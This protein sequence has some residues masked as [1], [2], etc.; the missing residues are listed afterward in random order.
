[1]ARK[2][3]SA[4]ADEKVTV[5]IGPVDVGRVD[6][7]VEEGFYASR[8]EF[9]RAAVRQLL[10]EHKQ[11]LND[12][13]VRSNFVIGVSG[14]SRDGLE[15]LRSRNMRLTVHVIGVL[16]IDDDVSPDLADAVIESIRVLGRFSAPTAVKKRL[17]AKMV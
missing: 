15:S 12:A 1:M 2:E 10:D 11:P 3:R 5:N 17:E 13:V 8:T 4:P 14:F 7:L 9:I 16:K 6:F